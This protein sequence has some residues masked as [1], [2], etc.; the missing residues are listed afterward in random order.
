MSVILGSVAVGKIG[1]ERGE[2][3]G[4]GLKISVEKN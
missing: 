2:R 1:D 4:A 3:H